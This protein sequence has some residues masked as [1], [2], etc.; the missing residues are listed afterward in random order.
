[1]HNLIKSWNG[2]TFRSRSTE[3]SDEEDDPEVVI[4]LTAKNPQAVQQ[5]VKFDGITREF[6]KVR[7]GHQA[8]GFIDH[9]NIKSTIVNIDSPEVMVKDF[10]MLF[11]KVVISITQ[12][13]L[14]VCKI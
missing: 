8:G 6:Y 12:I 2:I 4:H 1:M 3:L 10:V 9:L 5:Y 11:W 7:V 13:S 14:R